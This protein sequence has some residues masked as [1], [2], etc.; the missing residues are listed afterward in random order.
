MLWE[1][2]VKAGCK[3]VHANGDADVLMVQTAVESAKTSDTVVVGED[4]DLLVLFSFHSDIA[5]YELYFIPEPKKIS[6]K[7]RAWDIEI[8][9]LA[10]GRYLLKT[11]VHTCNTWM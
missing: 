6:T 4:I 11:L 9:K 2:L 3:T 8:T 7:Q 5:A 10:L 1:S